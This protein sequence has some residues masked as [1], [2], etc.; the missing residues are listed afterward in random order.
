MLPS[1]RHGSLYNLPHIRGDDDEIWNEV[2][3][4]IGRWRG[5]AVCTCH[6]TVASAVGRDS[7]GT[8]DDFA[9]RRLGTRSQA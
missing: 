5:R 1:K 9:V 3:V 7:P 2:A 4:G 6:Q 8:R